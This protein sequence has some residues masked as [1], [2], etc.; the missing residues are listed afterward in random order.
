MYDLYRACDA[1]K[2]KSFN[3]VQVSALLQQIIVKLNLPD[4][5]LKLNCLRML[6]LIAEDFALLFVDISFF[7]Y[8]K[9]QVMKTVKKLHYSL[10]INGDNSNFICFIF[11]SIF[12]SFAISIRHCWKIA[13]DKFA[14]GP[15]PSL[16]RYRRLFL[17][18]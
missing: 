7:M 2:R 3:P 12:L 16:L 9:V 8:T 5:I 14:L 17:L 6:K 13:T 11:I 10:K 15:S 1:N 18:V 4:N